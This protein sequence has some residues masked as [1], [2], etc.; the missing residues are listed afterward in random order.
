MSLKTAFSYDKRIQLPNNMIFIG[1]TKSVSRAICII[2][3]KNYICYVVGKDISI[4][5]FSGKRNE[6]L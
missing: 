1:A 5:E 4:S 3:S 6:K 2:F